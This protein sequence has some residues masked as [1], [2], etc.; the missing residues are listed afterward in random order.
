ME[1]SS[2]K[3]NVVRISCK[4]L[5]LSAYLYMVIPIVIFFIGWLKLYWGILFS[6]I[7]LF[8]LFYFMKRRYKEDEY[9]SI[10]LKAVVLIAAAVAVWVFL[11][12]IG[13]YFYQSWDFHGRNMI[14]RDLVEYS[15]PVIYPETGNALVYYHIFWMFPALVGKIFGKTLG[16]GA[17]NLTL[18]FWSFFGILI[19]MLLICKLLRLYRTKKVLL[20]LYI[21]IFWSGLNI[22]G[23]I[24]MATKGYAGFSVLGGGYGWPDSITAYQYTPNNALLEWVFNQTIVPWIAVPLF[25]Q[26]KRMDILAYLG[27]CVLPFAPFPFVGLFIIFAVWAV[28]QIIG[29]VRKKEYK[30]LF[31]TVFSIPNI[32]A[33]LSVFPVF[34]FFFGCNKVAN[35][36]MGIGGIGWYI[37][38]D[39]FTIKHFEILI[40][41][42][43]LEFL[44]YSVVLFKDHK[45][46]LLFYAA[47]LVLLICPLIR[48]GTARDFCMRASIPALLFLMILVMDKLNKAW[49]EKL[50]GSILILVSIIGI[51]SL[52][53]IS[54]WGAALNIITTTGKYP[55]IADDWVT[56]CDQNALDYFAINFVTEKPESKVFYKYLAKGKT[57]K[58]YTE[59]LMVSVNYRETHNLPLSGGYYNVSP[60][61]KEDLYLSTD[62][63]S[64]MLN[65]DKCTVMISSMKDGRYRFTFHEFQVALDVP[66]GIID[67]N[68][69]IGV[70]QINGLFP[71]DFTIEKIDEYYMICYQGY[72]LTYNS[73]DKSITMTVRTGNSDQLWLFARSAIK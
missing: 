20:M 3:G 5:I 27:L 30:E 49:E 39:N 36:S 52:S 56:L 41:F 25:L 16:W 71:Q 55:Y 6:G 47:N 23:E 4:K 7:L 72:A 70:W 14:F 17:A 37:E 67:E 62:G 57:E 50:S 63:S 73:D 34:L 60:K 13:G 29:F 10:E 45:R 68:G 12:G 66:G 43:I 58:K 64:V 15:W 21:F 48:I 33:I 2:L 42:Y 1:E 32:A 11:S 44:I 24:Y 69:T 9:F 22:L 26:E 8:G 59:D 38:P 54:D 40:V 31:K 53:A 28:A 65:Q 19:S 18:Y 35:G 61:Q 46:N 51:S